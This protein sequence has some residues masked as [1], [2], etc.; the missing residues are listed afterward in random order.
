M[1]AARYWRAIGL[2]A[3][4][5]GALEL[6][7]LHLYL[8]GARVDVAATLSSTVAPSSGAL[9]ALQD[10]DT[11]T[12]ARWLDVS[13]PGFA[14]VWDFGAGGAQDVLAVRL[15]SGALY[16][17]WLETLTLQYSSDGAAWVTVFS[18]PAFNW[19]GAS[20]MQ[21]IPGDSDASFEKTTLVLN[22]SGEDGSTSFTD[23]SFAPV[24]ITAYGAARV[25]YALGG[26]D[27]F[28]D[29]NGS[30]LG[31]L[32]SS[33][34]AFGL[35]D[36]CLEAEIYLTQYPAGEAIIFCMRNAAQNIFNSMV[37]LSPAG[38]VG[39]SDGTAWRESSIA[40]PLN[41]R[42]MVAVSRASG[43]VRVFIAGTKA[44][45][46]S[47]PIDIAGD[48][49]LLVGAYEAYGGNPAGGFFS[50]YIGGAMITKGVARFTADYT[51]VPP[52]FWGLAKG[53][54]PRPAPAPAPVFLS[55]GS[56]GDAAPFIS[57]SQFILD[58]EDFGRYRIPGPC[59]VEEKA[60]PASRPLRRRVQLYNQSSGR[61]I[62]ETWS[63]AATGEYSFDSIRGGDGTTYFVVAFDHTG[64]HRAVIADN[65]VPELMQEAA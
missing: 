57:V 1:P 24:S 55:G 30:Y 20:S 12:T 42:V 49:V 26:K 4:G 51:P 21:D 43:T 44:Y 52:P 29:G 2:Q 25:S 35:G 38:K 3:V 48:R 46:G 9:A 18:M 61:L 65:L 50:G 7:A 13:A 39:W 28:L 6:S 17:E 37:K 22:V 23:A 33:R 32:T 62:R 36:F 34:W 47:H 60:S 14:L 11:A 10:D 63:D 58:R 19:P 31:A 59:L 45:E 53:A 64:H 5:G 8:G 41:Q 40:V 56:A 16:A 15:G 54:G 27:L